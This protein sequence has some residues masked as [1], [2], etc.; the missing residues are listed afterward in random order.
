MNDIESGFPEAQEITKSFAKTFYAAS[1]FLP[2]AEK[3][4]SYAVYAVCRASDETVD[5]PSGKD[6]LA[7]L[8]KLKNNI[9]LA[10]GNA[11]LKIPLLAA[12]RETVNKYRIPKEYFYELLSG[13]RMDLEKNRYANLEELDDYCYKVAGVVGLIMARIF[14]CKDER[15]KKYAADLGIAMQLTNI[16][17][18]VR[19]DYLRGRI[20]LPRD[21]L[22]GFK[23]T[24]D[25]IASGKPNENFKNMLQFMIDRARQ[26][27]LNSQEGIKFIGKARLRF[28]VICMKEMYS[29]ILSEIERNNYDVFSS[30]AHASN[31]RKS[32]IILKILV[33]GKY[34]CA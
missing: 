19:E 9:D 30:R 22:E 12:F 31:L 25:N 10:Y 27:Y 17:R 23:V 3:R 8:E 4:A 1:L 28:V 7:D 6:T 20:Y 14:G 24:E 11:P 34:L 26:Y 21:I 18:D 5:N 29:R 32:R 15:S 16:L 13:M 33:K 2:K